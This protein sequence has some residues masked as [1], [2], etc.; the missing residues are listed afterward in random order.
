MLEATIRK[1]QNR[2]IAAAQEI[3]HLTIPHPQPLSHPMGE[4]G[5]GLSAFEARVSF[6]TRLK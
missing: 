4:G 5:V 2:T 6:T 3:R 1:Y